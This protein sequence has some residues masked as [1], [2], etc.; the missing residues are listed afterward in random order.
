MPG[1]RGIP[2]IEA[3]RLRVS[4]A[5]ALLIAALSAA[6]GLLPARAHA[7]APVASEPTAA[8]RWIADDTD[9]NRA[10]ELD[11]RFAALNAATSDEEATPIIAEIWSLWHTSGNAEVDDLMSRILSLAI[12]G[13]GADA[14]Q[15]IDEVIRLKPDFPE[16]WNQRATLRYHQG[17]FAES[18]AD[19][20]EVLKRE[21][22]HFGA[23]SGMGLIAL[24][25]GDEKGALAA[26]RRALA[27]NPFLA[28]RHL[29]P[30][31]ERKLEGRPL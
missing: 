17:R 4:A 24:A 30:I 3:R 6:A 15:L 29:I 31:L 28:H 16:G 18:L 27:V 19:C 10:A 11:R 2:G 21:P 26:F 20:V 1:L 7:A 5:A 14:E 9:R 23:L 12:F 25:Q 22:R 13:Q 8:L